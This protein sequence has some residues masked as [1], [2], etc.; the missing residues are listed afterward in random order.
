[1]TSLASSFVCLFAVGL[2]SPNVSQAGSEIKCVR[3]LGST[4]YHINLTQPPKNYLGHAGYSGVMHMHIPQLKTSLQKITRATCMWH[5]LMNQINVYN[6]QIYTLD[7]CGV[8]QR[9][10]NGTASQTTLQL[11]ECDTNEHVTS[12]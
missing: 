2:L 8:G 4:L 5:C 1:M 11:S 7:D 6:L 12:L 9:Q 3:F 10:L